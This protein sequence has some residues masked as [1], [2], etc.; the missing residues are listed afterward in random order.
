MKHR[1]SFEAHVRGD[2]AAAAAAAAKEAA[3]KE[4]TGSLTPLRRK[5][6]Q[7]MSDTF[8]MVVEAFLSFDADASGTLDKKEVESLLSAGGAR[9]MS[10]RMYKGKKKKRASGTGGTGAPFMPPNKG[11]SAI[12]T[13]RWNKMDW[14]K[15]GQISFREFLYSFSTWVGL[16]TD[17]EGDDED[18][19][20]PYT[21]RMGKKT[22]VK[23]ELAQE[24]FP[25]EG[26]K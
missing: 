5:G 3:E 14:N 7:S 16:G 11:I 24:L 19:G 23:V 26:G 15:D 1:I 2:G 21:P 13:D 25:E 17:D 20:K 6:G 22:P 9:S 18:D 8:Q 10:M 12:G 4:A